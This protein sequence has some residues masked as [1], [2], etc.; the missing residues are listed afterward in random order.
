MRHLLSLDAFRHFGRAASALGISQPAL[1]KSL[2]RLE[3]EVGAKLFE[4]TRAR[5]V[6]TALGQEILDRS[7]HLVAE[8]DELQ[9]WLH[10]R[11]SQ[12]TGRV[13][14]GLGP[15]MSESWVTDAI[16]Q[17]AD[18]NSDVQVTVRL[19]HWQQ[20][21]QWLLDDCLE[22]YV[23]DTGHAMGDPRFEIHPL[24]PQKLIWFSRAGHPLAD[25]PC[26]IS[27]AEL[28]CYP[29]ATP[30]MP[31]WAVEWLQ[32]GLADSQHACDRRHW[33]AIEC[34]SYATLKRVVLASQCVSAALESTLEKEVR[35]GTIAIL[36]IDAPELMTHAGIVRRQD[37][38]LS[39]A[40]ARLMA[41]MVSTYSTA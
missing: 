27:R 29:L 1:T 25:R 37:R 19:D 39:P 6:P 16:A 26:Q 31:P 12:Q 18:S 3:E 13:A 2:Q 24:P 23:A 8:A 40:A 11:N 5:V 38:T 41:A 35:D 15:A 21:L 10:A 22:F 4:R 33:P 34:E 14:I 17:F 30:K 28:L 36:D 32:A 7:R 9:Q 20:L